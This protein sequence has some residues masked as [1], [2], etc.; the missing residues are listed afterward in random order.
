MLKYIKNL[1]I[2]IVI[3][4]ILFVSF[5][6]IVT[7][8]LSD[9]E[10]KT[11]SNMYNRMRVVDNTIK[12]DFYVEV[13]LRVLDRDIIEKQ[14]RGDAIIYCL[15]VSDNVIEMIEIGRTKKFISDYLNRCSISFDKISS[16]DSASELY[17]NIVMFNSMYIP[18]E[19]YLAIFG[20]QI[21]EIVEKEEKE[22]LNVGL[23]LRVYIC[24]IFVFYLIVYAFS[25]KY[26]ENR[27]TLKNLNKFLRRYLLKK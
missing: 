8:P 6:A 18:S 19:E 5:Y 4:S 2:S 12:N 7:S 17:E 10:Y 3:F 25:L 11:I 26:I 16:L 20:T 23:Q 9:L 14:L 24:L 13:G 1:F 27:I 21:G 22:L 15:K